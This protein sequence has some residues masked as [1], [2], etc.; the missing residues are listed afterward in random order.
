IAIEQVYRLLFQCGTSTTGCYGAL[1]PPG[2]EKY[3][4]A[5]DTPPLIIIK[6]T[7]PLALRHTGAWKVAFADFVTAM[8]ALFMVMWLMSTDTSKQQAIAGY[9]QDPKAFEQS[10][11]EGSRD[12]EQLAQNIERAL[13]K[14]P[15]WPSLQNQVAMEVTPDGLRIELLESER[16]TFFASANAGPTA[17]GTSTLTLIGGELSKLP[18]KVIIE[19]HTD[20]QSFRGRRDYSNWELSVD[21][22][23]QARRLLVQNG[24]DPQRIVEVR[25]FADVRLRKADDPAHPSNRRISLIVKYKNR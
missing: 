3:R 24:M 23:N 21:R 8:M 20:S 18:N 10:K 25:G 9:F 4:Q 17:F 6:R 19:G 7:R 12:L 2:N 16:Q 15:E 11:A 1:R 5:S 22:A 14:S 13:L